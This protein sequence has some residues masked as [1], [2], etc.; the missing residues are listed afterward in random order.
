MSPY[1]Y[2]IINNFPGGLQMCA[3][4]IL[5]SPYMKG[6]MFSLGTL[7]MQKFYALYDMD[8]NTIGFADSVSNTPAN[9]K[10]FADSVSNTLSLS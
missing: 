2:T 1:D 4:G 8:A 5:G 6:S 9:T 10:G 3:S 7:F